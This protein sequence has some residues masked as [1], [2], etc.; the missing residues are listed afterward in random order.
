MCPLVVFGMAWLYHARTGWAERGPRAADRAH[1]LAVYVLAGFAPACLVYGLYQA[2]QRIVDAVV[3]NGWP[4]TS[5]A[6]A[7]RAIAALGACRRRGVG[8]RLAL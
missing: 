4:G 5:T 8:C 3:G 7:W 6:M 2:V 1:D